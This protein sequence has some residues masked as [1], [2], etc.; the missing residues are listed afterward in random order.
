MYLTFAFS[1]SQLRWIYSMDHGFKL[2]SVISTNGP[3]R[4]GRK[5]PKRI[6]VSL[7]SHPPIR[8]LDGGGCFHGAFVRLCSFC[9][10]P[11]EDFRGLALRAHCSISIGNA[12]SAMDAEKMTFKIKKATGQR[13]GKAYS[14]TDPYTAV[15]LS[16]A[17]SAS[18]R[19]T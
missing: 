3:H 17:C 4:I 6:G 7:I 5:F 16:G 13:C 10:E 2:V 8:A 11:L 9:F 12:L 1:A 14:R 19:R 18:R 15:F